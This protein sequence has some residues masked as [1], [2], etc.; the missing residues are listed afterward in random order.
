MDLHES[1][2]RAI[3]ARRHDIGAD[4]WATPGGLSAA[5]RYREIERNVNK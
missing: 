4:F 5:V 3:L 1:D 2:I